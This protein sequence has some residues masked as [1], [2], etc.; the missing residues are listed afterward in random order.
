MER[1]LRNIQYI[2]G[3]GPK[4]SVQLNRLGITKVFD[5]LWYIPRNYLSKDSVSAII[6]LRPGS[7]TTIIGRVKAT[8]KS[9]SRRGMHVFKAIIQ[10]NSG[11][12][13]AV[14]FNQ[15]YID[16]VIK[17][18]QEVFIYGKTNNN[19]GTT[20]INVYEYDLINNAQNQFILPVYSLT[21]GIN[22]KFMRGMVD[23]V[24][25]EYL[26]YYPEILH[27]DILEKYNLCSINYAFYNIHFP[28]NRESYIKARRRLALE[29]LLLFQLRL[30][31]EHK[32]KT[33][34]KNYIIHQEKS[35]LVNELENNLPYELTRAQKKVVTEILRDMESPIKMNRLLQG[36][37][38]AGKTVVA[39]IA[40]A[41]AIASNYQVAFMVP[42]EILAEQHFHS[43]KKFFCNFNVEIACLTG[44]TS[45]G[46]RRQIVNAVSQGQ[47]DIL[48][49]THALIQDTVEFAHLGLVIIDEQHRFGVRQ[50]AKLSQKGNMPDVLV[51]TAT[52]IPRTLAL[53][54]Y[55]ELECSI[56]DEL[57]PGRKPV[58]TKWI[59][60]KDSYKVY[61]FVKQQLDD[62]QV[63]AYI[64]CPLVEES[65][66]QDL[67]D[68]I[69]LYNQL[70]KGIFKDI[71]MELVHGRMKSAEK[72]YVMNKFKNG[73]IKILIGTTVIE[74]GV[75][76]PQATIMVIEHAERF[77]LSQLHQLRGRVGRGSK[78]SFCF[79]L[80][81]PGSEAA[82]KR[83]KLMEKYHDGFKLAE[84]DLILR[85][86]GEFWGIKQHGLG[87]LKI[88]DLTRDY[89]LV[90]LSREISN[91]INSETITIL[92]QYIKAKFD[93][94]ICN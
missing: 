48:V 7:N 66:K 65:E 88:A 77:G 53:T 16:D 19:R 30:K 24:L 4:R 60:K 18:G 33:T 58:K 73:E 43:M 70:K 46:E 57:P 34:L 41:K 79:L 49:G 40:I 47:I 64:V 29:E 2:K 3:V 27:D 23:K 93:D 11:V 51:M 14:W 76:I 81:S 10:D 74:V 25:H 42:T 39:A 15:P 37:V 28:K 59:D 1:L 94:I 52:P 6:K 45:A 5:V 82:E 20:E 32:Y 84:Q 12:I 22:L 85:G 69:S 68:V 56:I 83:L 63:Q 36:D 86:P 54:V 87:Q 55:G 26:S 21:D 50:R 91:I 31:Q 13:P 17:K 72:E 89:N 38:G 75:D 71:K 61:N 78:Q 62:N 67:Q 92:D 8:R 44:G 90:K 9:I 80:S 35:N